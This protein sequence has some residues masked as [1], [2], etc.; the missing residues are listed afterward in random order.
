[1]SL[2]ALEEEQLLLARLKDQ[3]QNVSFASAA[4]IAGTLDITA[5]CPAAYL[6]PGESE[7]VS[8]SQDGIAQMEERT[9]LLVLT[10]KN[11]PDPKNLTAD[12]QVAGDLMGKCVQALAGWKPASPFRPVRYAG[13]EQPEVYAGHAEFPLRFTVRRVFNGTG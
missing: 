13:R 3:V 10:V 5:L 7:V 2:N 11:V 8:W 6:Q 12:F 9:W 1:M 4:S